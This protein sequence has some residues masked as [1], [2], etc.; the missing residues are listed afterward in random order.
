MYELKKIE[1][2]KFI[3]TLLVVYVVYRYFLGGSSLIKGPHDT[4]QTK[5]KN[6]D[7]GEFIDYTEVDED[8]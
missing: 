2:L 8:N 1:K 4:T 6:T 5:K 7:D 3:L